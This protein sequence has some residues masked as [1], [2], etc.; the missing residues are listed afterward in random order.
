M[1]H[2]DQD[3]HSLLNQIVNHLCTEGSD[4]LAE[5]MRLLLNHAMQAERAKALGAA[6]YERSTTRK[7]HVNGFKPKTLQTRLGELTVD[8]PQVRGDLDFYPSAQLQI[9]AL[10]L[11]LRYFTFAASFSALSSSSV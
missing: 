10:S 2:P 4:G 3:D 6:P 1:T 9:A 5:A 8:V 11:R 7:G